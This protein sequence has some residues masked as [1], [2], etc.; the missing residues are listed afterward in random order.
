MDIELGSVNLGRPNSNSIHSQKMNGLRRKTMCRLFGGWCFSATKIEWKIDKYFLHF[1]KTNPNILLRCWLT[2][3]SQYLARQTLDY[4]CTFKLTVSKTRQF[5]LRFWMFFHQFMNKSFFFCC[6]FAVYF[7]VYLW[8]F[9]NA[10]VFLKLFLP[11]AFHKLNFSIQFSSAH[12]KLSLS[13][14]FLSTNIFSFISRNNMQ[15][16]ITGAGSQGT[17]GCFLTKKKP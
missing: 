12:A 2:K 11:N 7:R 10:R 1:Y 14:R 9:V 3:I 5:F 16:N 4:F 17:Q 15:V 6:C 8:T 13:I